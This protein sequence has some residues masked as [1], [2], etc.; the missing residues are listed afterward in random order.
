MLAYPAAFYSHVRKVLFEGAMTQK[1]V[2]GINAILDAFTLYGDGNAQRLAYILATPNVETGGHYEAIHEIGARSY[3]NKYEPGTKLGKALGNTVI[4]D[5]FLYRGRGLV[6]ITGRAN[7][8]KVGKA[9]GIDLIGNPDLALDLTIAAKILVIGTLK[10]WFT[11]KGLAAYIDDT[12]EAD[13]L[14]L[15]EFI[16]ARRTVNGQDKAAAI[17]GHALVFEAALKVGGYTVQRAP[18]PIPTVPLPA[19]PRKGIGGWII[20]A[21]VIVAV[22]VTLAVFTPVF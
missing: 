1:Q 2:D 6:Q 4:G 13:D 9:L 8:A 14:D 19:A 15:A 12:D 20:A 21:V 5:G 22:L 11:G 17:G 18:K 16:Q 10:G 3:F 7:Y